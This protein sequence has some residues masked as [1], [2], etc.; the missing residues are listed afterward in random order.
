[1]RGRLWWIVALI[2]AIPGVAR[3]EPLCVRLGDRARLV[4]EAGATLIGGEDIAEVFAVRPGALYAAGEKGAYRL[5]D[6]RGARLTDDEFAMIDDAGDCLIYRQG[7]L[8]GAMDAEGRILLSA[9]W[10]QLVSDGAGGWLAL[11]GDPLDETA[12]AILRVDA[13]GEATPTGATTVIGLSPL[14]H[15]R[16]PVMTPG[17]RY[18]AIDGRGNWVI[19]AEWRYI[20]P[21]EDGLARAADETGLGLIDADGVEVIPTIYDWLER[22]DGLITAADAGGVDVY[23]PDGLRVM[24][25]VEGEHLDATVV[26]AFLAVRDGGTTTLRDRSGSVVF[27]ADGA[28]TFEEGVDGQ[29]I[30]SDGPW[31]ERCAWVM[32]PDGS[33]ASG[34]YQR[35]LPLCEGLYAFMTM[36]GIDYYSAD[37]GRVQTSWN[38]ESVRYGLMDGA[39]NERLPAAYDAIEALGDGRLLLTDAAGAC[40]AD[41]G[42]SILASWPNGAE[43]P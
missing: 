31:G 36:D 22:G 38:Y 23:T 28:V 5:Y 3:A 41:S 32:N 2:L 1:M 11:Q 15:D 10:T 13:G 42:G 17:G 6:A 4:D 39:G 20:G 7:A 8:Y 12:D 18:G 43:E 37:L 33:A 21:F 19:P 14:R 26:G 29:L 9:Q 16:I 27:E 25:S 35:L 24:Y 30:A 34:R 40:L